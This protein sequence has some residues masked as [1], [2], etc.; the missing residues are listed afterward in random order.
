[1]AIIN[2]QIRSIVTTPYPT[3]GIV[4]HAGARSNRIGNQAFRA[5]HA[6]ASHHRLVSSTD[7]RMR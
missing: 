7:A 3:G 6:A 4:R 2:A 5:P 1:M